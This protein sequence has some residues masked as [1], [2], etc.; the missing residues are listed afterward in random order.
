LKQA[1]LACLDALDPSDQLAVVA[2]DHEADLLV[3]LQRPANRTVI[4][5]AVSRLESGRGTNVVPG[6]KKAF[7]L[8][9][10]SRIKTKH[11]ILVSDGESP[12]DGV[13]DVVKNMRD[14]NTEGSRMCTVCL[15]RGDVP[16]CRG[17]CR[18]CTYRAPAASVRKR[19]A[20]AAPQQRRGRLGATH[21]KYSERHRRS[22]TARPPLR[23]AEPCAAAASATTYV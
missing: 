16:K 12:N 13:A 22:R 23:R 8:L 20:M 1:A 5:K 7:D 10:E 4:A 15:T 19:E 17:R 21:A 9:R 6:L 2:V 14:A 3:P 18:S 11:V